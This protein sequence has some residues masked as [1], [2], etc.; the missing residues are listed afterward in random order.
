MFKTIPEK[1]LAS[2]NLSQHRSSQKFA[3]NDELFFYMEDLASIAEELS[4]KISTIFQKVNN[5]HFFSSYAKNVF[6][7]KGSFPKRLSPSEEPKYQ[8]Q[9][10]SEQILYMMK[11]IESYERSDFKFL[12][13]EKN[14]ETCKQAFLNAIVSVCK[15]SV[16]GNES[17]GRDNFSK[18][19][20]IVNEM[21]I[22]QDERKK[23][24]N[25]L[26]SIKNRIDKSISSPSLPS[27]QSGKIGVMEDVNENKYVTHSL[28]MNKVKDSTKSAEE[29]DKEIKEGKLVDVVPSHDYI[30]QNKNFGKY[31]AKLTGMQVQD[32]AFAPLPPRIQHHNADHEVLKK[33][34]FEVNGPIQY[35]S[36]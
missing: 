2:E 7:E 24:L 30:T 15:E 17:G 29:I 1:L 36:N 35:T 25:L 14:F 34:K 26:Q 13:K 12:L 9:Y 23:L 4:S 11:K 27:P 6:F 32:P 21:Y 20:N 28:G 16:L 18:F 19:I 5:C 10:L 22:S 33:F 3:K 8:L 31:E